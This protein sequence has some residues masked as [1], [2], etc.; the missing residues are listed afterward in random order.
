M[1]SVSHTDSTLLISN[2]FLYFGLVLPGPL[3]WFK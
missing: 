2:K 3:G 1:H